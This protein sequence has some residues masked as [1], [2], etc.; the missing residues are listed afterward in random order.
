MIDLG[1]IERKPIRLGINRGGCG[2]TNT[3]TKALFAHVAACC[4][5]LPSVANLLVSQGWSR[6]QVQ[7]SIDASGF[8]CGLGKLEERGIYLRAGGS[9]F[10]CANV[11]VDNN[12]AITSNKFFIICF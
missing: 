2:I 12:T 11:I 1:E 10:S 9:L 5:V 4:Q 6:E 7:R 8:A 3:F